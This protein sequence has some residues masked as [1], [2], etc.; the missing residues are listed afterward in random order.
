MTLNLEEDY[1]H[2]GVLKAI[3]TSETQSLVIPY[4][5]SQNSKRDIILQIKVTNLVGINDVTLTHTSALL[6]ATT[7]TA[8]FISTKPVTFS[9][10]NPFPSSLLFIENSTVG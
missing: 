4:F 8:Y 2:M 3:K 5:T 6:S 7:D 10:K 1:I 9:F